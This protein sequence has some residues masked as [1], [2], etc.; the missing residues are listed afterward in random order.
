MRVFGELFLV[1]GKKGPKEIECNY[2]NENFH[3]QPSVADLGYNTRKTKK[4]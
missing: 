3:E 2:A 4:D 1:N